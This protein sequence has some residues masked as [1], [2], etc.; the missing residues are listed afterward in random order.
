MKPVEYRRLVRGFGIWRII[1]DVE[2]KRWKLDLN[3]RRPGP[4][5]WRPVNTFALAEV[6]AI[7]VAERKTGDGAWDH[8]G[9]GT[10]ENF[11]DL[12]LWKLEEDA[13]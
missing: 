4:E 13:D 2:A 9:F 1:Y 10:G 3:D 6:A 8:C 11:G 12:T 7:T 5:V